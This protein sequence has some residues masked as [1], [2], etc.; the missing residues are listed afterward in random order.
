MT[1]HTVR[2]TA[3]PLNAIILALK[4]ALSKTWTEQRRAL[5]FDVLED[6]RT[7]GLQESPSKAELG[8]LVG[9][10]EGYLGMGL[11]EAARRPVWQADVAAYRV[12]LQAVS[13]DFSFTLPD[14]EALDVLRGQTLFWVQ[15]SYTR[16]LQDEMVEALNEY[17]TEGKTR[18]ELAARLERF[19][20]SKEPTMQGYFD[21][22]ADHNATRIAEIGHVTGYERAGVEYVEIVAVLDERTSPICRH[23]HGRIIPTSALSSQ[24]ERLLEAAKKLDMK[25]ARKAQPMLSGASE[26]AVLLEPKTSKIV[27]QGVGMPPYHFRCRTTTVA[28]F[29]PADTWQKASH[30]VIDG[31]APKREIPRLLDYARNA[32]WGTHPRV[33]ERSRGGDGR[34]HPTAFVHFKTHGERE[35]GF[36]TLEEYNQ[37]LVSLVRRA[38]RD[39]YLVIRKKEHPYP[40][41]IFRDERTQETAVINLKGQQF[42]T[43]FRPNNKRFETL[44]RGY[45]I[46]LK[47]ENARGVMKWI[48]FMPI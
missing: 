42:A 4:T 11:A 33:W 24:K 10:A 39:V 26:A 3:L 17:F 41:L 46:S 12:G 38:G 37:R 44:L 6:G 30:W 21:L 20:T 45:D 31:E 8:R 34:Q 27:A 23:L 36:R 9:R 25:A 29:E 2:K 14:M 40:V 43:F 48:R 28:H 18:I 15:N 22:L 47:L 5:L 32:R 19:L 35:M 13:A 7:L 1:P 16:W